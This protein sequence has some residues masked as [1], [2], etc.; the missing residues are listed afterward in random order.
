MHKHTSLYLI[1]YNS[2]TQ[3]DQRSLY[4]TLISKY[5]F[6]YILELC[7]NKFSLLALLSLVCLLSIYSLPTF[8]QD[9]KNTPLSAEVRTK[10]QQA[11]KSVGLVYVRN[12]N[13]SKTTPQPQGSAVVIR[14]DGVLI[15]NHHVILDNQSTKLFDEIYVAF[16]QQDDDIATFETSYR[17]RVILVDKEYDLAL[18]YIIS[19]VKGGR[20]P[21]TFELPSL[22]LSDTKSTQLL[23][24]IF[25]VGFPA[26]GGE[27]I[28]VTNGIIEG[29]DTKNNWLKT[30]ARVTPGNS[31]GAAINL[32]GKLVGIPTKVQIEKGFIDKDK[33]DCPETSPSY[34]AIG[35]L[36]PASLVGEMLAL[37]PLPKN[38]TE[39]LS[40]Q[41]AVIAKEN[42]LV[43]ISGII[44]DSDKKSPIN[45]ALVGVIPLSDE[46]ITNNN[47]ISWAKTTIEGKFLLNNNLKPGKYTLKVKAIGYESLLCNVFLKDGQNKLELHLKMLKTTEI[48]NT[49]AIPPVANK[50]NTNN[51][52]NI[53]SKVNITGVTRSSTTQQPITGA[54]VGLIILGSKE[55]TENNLLT[56]GVANPNGEVNFNKPITP[57]RYT[58][59]AKATGYEDLTIDIEVTNKQVPIVIQLKSLL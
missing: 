11:T 52:N 22:E 7:K 54:I 3:K 20:I 16:S 50:N 37:V 26:I 40:S 41:T 56:W 33:D 38:S 6:S 59:K 36:R 49:T 45:D 34:G 27:T 53:T 15:T 31:G 46:E 21:P 23:D 43:Q 47:L 30:N 42:K 19:D 55:V 48:K 13:G 39:N 1:R 4:K 12:L 28:T 25:I 2:S 14:K 9:K 57:G 10:V 58:L 29:K 35:F 32:S 51:S 24:N 18:L 17:T 5:S 8:A 44:Q